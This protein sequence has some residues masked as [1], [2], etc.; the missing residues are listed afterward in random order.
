MTLPTCQK[1]SPSQIGIVHGWNI[2]LDPRFECFACENAHFVSRASCL[3]R[4][5]QPLSYSSPTCLVEELGVGAKAH[6]ANKA[7]GRTCTSK[8]PVTVRNG[9]P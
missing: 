5:H 2:S 6:P 9:G 4:L 8:I 3:V 7:L 1:S